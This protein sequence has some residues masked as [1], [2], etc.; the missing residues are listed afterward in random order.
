MN[1]DG[2]RRTRL[3]NSTGLL[4]DEQLSGNGDNYRHN[5]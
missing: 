5:R 4:A 1:D 3:T 2:C